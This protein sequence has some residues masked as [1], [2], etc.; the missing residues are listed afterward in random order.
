MSLFSRLVDERFLAHPQRATSIG[1][2]AAVLAFC[3]FAWRYYVD[4]IWRGDLLAVGLTAVVVKLAILIWSGL[5]D[6]AKEENQS[7]PCKKN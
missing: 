2:T 7:W 5:R 1:G 4:G 6:Q 3:L